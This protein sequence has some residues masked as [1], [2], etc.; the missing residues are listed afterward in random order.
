MLKKLIKHE[1]K[2]TAKVNYVLLGIMLLITVFGWLSFKAPMWSAAFGSVADYNFSG[3][4]LLAII[5]LISYFLA[6]VALAYAL[7]IYLAVHFY[8]SMY[9][10]QG[11]LT[12]T[13][14]ATPNQLF[15]SKVLVS[16]IWYAIFSVVMI[17]SIIAIVVSMFGTML[18][19]TGGTFGWD[20][21]KILFGEFEAEMGVQMG[22]VMVL[23]LVVAILTPFTTVITMFGS[24]TLGQLAKNNKGVM[25]FLWYIA[26]SF[27]SAI[28]LYVAEMVLMIGSIADMA[29]DPF[30]M[31]DSM[32]GGTYIIML[33]MNI[34]ISVVLYLVSVWINKKKI[35]LN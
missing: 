29:T 1:F 13:L 27:G 17:I 21:L 31:I 28:V 23:L 26:I 5:A 22:G 16:S 8:R 25:G 18:A 24:L 4:D 14:P 35:N 15:F 3:V 11:Y 33:V 7:I 20:E 2:A 34:V 9:T 12:H 30:A 10:D 32:Y 19:A 6:L